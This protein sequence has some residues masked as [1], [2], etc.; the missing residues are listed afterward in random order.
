MIE[1]ANAEE[2]ALAIAV[3]LARGARSAGQDRGAGDAGPRAGAPR[4]G[5]AVALERGGRRF[6]A[7]IARRTPAGVFARLVAEAALGGLAPV[8]LLAL[9]KHPLCR[10]DAAGAHRRAIAILERAVLRGPRPQPGTA[11][12]DHALATL[13]G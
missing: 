13:R 12:L 6:A 11:G 5:G 1:A 3:A 8:P 9:L 2:E 10:L 4:A 7:A